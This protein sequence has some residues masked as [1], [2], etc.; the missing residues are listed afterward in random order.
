MEF[1]RF[2]SAVKS[3]AVGITVIYTKRRLWQA[4]RS[5]GTVY[6][7]LSTPQPAGYASTLTPAHYPEQHTPA[8]P[9]TQ[10]TS[11]DTVTPLDNLVVAPCSSPLKADTPCTTA[12]T[13]LQPASHAHAATHHAHV[14]THAHTPTHVHT[15]THAHVPM[16]AHVAATPPDP[17]YTSLPSITHYSGTASIGA[18]MTDYTYSSPYTQY[19]TTYPAY[20][21]G[22]GG[23][24]NMGNYSGSSNG[25]NNGSGGAVTNNPNSVTN[26]QNHNSNNNN[27]NGNSTA[28]R[29]RMLQSSLGSPA[30]L[31]QD[32]CTT[33]LPVSLPS[34]GA[35]RGDNLINPQAF[36]IVHS[37]PGSSQR[38]SE[39]GATAVTVYSITR[40]VSS[41]T[42]Q[43]PTECPRHAP[44]P[45][46]RPSNP[47][48][49]SHPVRAVY[50]RPA[51][52]YR[53]AVARKDQGVRQAG[54]IVGHRAAM[55]TVTRPPETRV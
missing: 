10:C 31:R 13:V 52:Q 5:R 36:R 39:G 3:E 18:S 42:V 33:L 47:A 4:L 49:K 17:A 12:L 51:A 25:G 37:T 50:Q 44:H 28:A 35:P 27:N 21:Y 24:L 20:G 1:Y 43:Q 34:S 11:N 32:R 38:A 16:H 40:R 48:A 41:R 9:P 46:R 8:S 29:L 53:A 14:S 23:L 45:A 54:Q 7:P 6:T 2:S 26:N 55:N 19:T 15:T 30:C 22:T